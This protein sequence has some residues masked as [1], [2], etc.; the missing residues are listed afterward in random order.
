MTQIIT[1]ASLIMDG[2]MQIKEKESLS[3]WIPTLD[4]NSK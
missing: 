1:M 4:K 2:E 3:I